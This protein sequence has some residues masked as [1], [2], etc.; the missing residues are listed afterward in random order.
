MKNKL[1]SISLSHFGIWEGDDFEKIIDEMEDLHHNTKN[2]IIEWYSENHSR[3]YIT[4]KFHKKFISNSKIHTKENLV[5][6]KWIVNGLIIGLK[7]S[8]YI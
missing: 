5:G 8:G 3:D 1:N 4:S 7:S 2:S 6:L